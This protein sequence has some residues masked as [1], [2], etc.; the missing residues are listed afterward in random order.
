MKAYHYFLLLIILASCSKYPTRTVSPGFIPEANISR[1]PFQV[2][3]ADR[4]RKVGDSAQVMRL[5]FLST[6][7]LIRIEDDGYLLLAHFSGMFFEFQGDTILDISK[8]SEQ[9][10]QRLNNNLNAV[11]HPVNVQLLYQNKGKPNYY[12][13][14][15]SGGC[16]SY[17]IAL[18]SPATNSV[19]I[20]ATFPELCLSW[21]STSDKKPES[22]EIQI[23]NIFDELVDT[24][25]SETTTLNLNLSQYNSE[26]GLYL[27]TIYDSQDHEIRSTE[28]GIKVGRVYYYTPQTCD[29]NTSLKALEMAL[30]VESHH[31]YYDASDYYKLAAELSER[32][33]FTE[34]L[35]NYKMRK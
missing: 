17:P 4:A 3:Y 26:S 18:I 9:A 1:G 35:N 22:F 20:S 15:V 10:S 23:K 16:A 7:D 30:Y 31:Y 11:E 25:I 8:L 32:P 5:K 12:P 28:L 19:E 27:L 14:A 6:F 2:I 21:E 24:I 29:I 34:F 33:I 13:G